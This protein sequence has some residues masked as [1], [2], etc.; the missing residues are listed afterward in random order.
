[1]NGLAGCYV[2]TIGK[3]HEYFDLTR[4]PLNSSVSPWPRK[5][6][7]NGFTHRVDVATTFITTKPITATA[8]SPTARMKNS[9]AMIALK[10]SNATKRLASG[11]PA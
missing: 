3:Q 8:A 4:T 6:P 9:P 10:P 1:M 11:F 7:K 5:H 2:S